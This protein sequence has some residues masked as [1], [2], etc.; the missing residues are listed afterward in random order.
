M[1]KRSK[2]VKNKLKAA[3]GPRAT[4]WPP[5]FYSIGSRACAD[6]FRSKNVGKRREIVVRYQPYRNFSSW[7]NVKKLKYFAMNNNITS[8]I[9]DSQ[10]T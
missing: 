4:H 6:V 3:C 5:L 7:E 10:F 9:A 8:G 1:T 2:G